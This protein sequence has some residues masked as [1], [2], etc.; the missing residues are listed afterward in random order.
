[1][2]KPS[3]VY[4][5]NMTL[6]YFLTSFMSN[7]DTRGLAHEVNLFGS[8]KREDFMQRLSPLAMIDR[9]TVDNAL[10]SLA[11]ELYRLAYPSSASTA[12]EK[13]KI[14]VNSMAAN[15]PHFYDYSF[16]LFALY[17]MSS[18]GQF[19]VDMILGPTPIYTKSVVTVR[20]NGI[21]DVRATKQLVYPFRRLDDTMPH[22]SGGSL[23]ALFG[24]GSTPL[25]TMFSTLIHTTQDLRDLNASGQ[26][27]EEFIYKRMACTVETSDIEKLRDLI[28]Q[29]SYATLKGAKHL[30]FIEQ[31]PLQSN[32]IILRL[33]ECEQPKAEGGLHNSMLALSIMLSTQYTSIISQYAA[34]PAAT[35]SVQEGYG[36][37]FPINLVS[38]PL[39]MCK[40][41]G[42]P[43]LRSSKASLIR[44]LDAIVKLPL[45]RA[46]ACMFAIKLF[47]C[48]SALTHG[49]IHRNG[50]GFMPIVIG[51]FSRM[52]GIYGRRVLTST[53]AKAK[54]S[55]MEM[56]IV[57]E[58]AR[59][60][61][62]TVLPL[63]VPSNVPPTPST[64]VADPI[65]VLGLQLFSVFPRLQY[66]RL[67]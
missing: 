53:A 10:F 23:V 37:D 16:D 54:R 52:Y 40:V 18:R 61:A 17:V 26:M 44:A 58:A 63:I 56:I 7:R 8:M 50:V 5:A 13:V 6:E 38:Y 27:Q 59:T 2:E 24:N 29:V 15:R 1:V 42:V 9:P 11:T 4:F 35:L 19:P 55:A 21:V 3:K 39:G 31:G 33:Y 64:T 45:E 65:G 49:L 62:H 67:T 14:V 28:P 43:T 47:I 25:F 22:D 12:G 46:Y 41:L 32:N 51:Y 66:D 60:I 57:N 20:A 34:T 36:A 30:V 48:L